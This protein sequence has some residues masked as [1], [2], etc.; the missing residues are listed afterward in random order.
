MGYVLLYDFETFSAKSNKTE[1]GA[2]TTVANYYHPA[3][4]SVVFLW[5]GRETS[6]IVSVGYYDGKE[7]MEMFFKKVFQYAFSV[8]N[9]LR[10]INNRVHPT[11]K[12]LDLF[13]ETT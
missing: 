7:C 11:K 2:S 9:H 1:M 8:T 12:E 4:F 6:R 10:Q 3:T 5:H 13:H